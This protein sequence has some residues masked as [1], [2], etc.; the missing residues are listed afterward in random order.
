MDVG[1]GAFARDVHP[2]NISSQT[3]FPLV[4]VMLDGTVVRDVHPENMPLYPES[5]TVAS[6]RLPAE[7]SAV[8]PLNISSH[9][10]AGTL[11]EMEG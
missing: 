6:G 11:P 9:A 1:V 3:E 5:S 4:P 2:A 10:E 7:T 8:Q